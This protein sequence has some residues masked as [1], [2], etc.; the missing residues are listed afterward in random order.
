MIPGVSDRVLVLDF[1]RIIAQGI[2]A[3]VQ[4][5]P[6]VIK[7]YLGEEFSIRTTDDMSIPADN[8]R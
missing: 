6:D 3:E 7:A 5:N 4:S 8:S 1:G 2:P